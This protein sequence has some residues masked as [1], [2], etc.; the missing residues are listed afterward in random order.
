MIDPHGH[1]NDY[2]DETDDDSGD[3]WNCGGEGYVSSC[4]SE[5][6]CVDP[7]SGCEFCTRPCEVCNPHGDRA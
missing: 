6:A 1:E 7:E 5:Y 4:E 3:C 2:P